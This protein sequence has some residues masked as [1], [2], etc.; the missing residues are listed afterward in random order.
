MSG[1]AE[2]PGEP[3]A[4]IT[5]SHPEASRRCLDVSVF[6]ARCCGAVLSRPAHPPHRAVPA[7]RR[8]QFTGAALGRADQAAAGIDRRGEHRRRGCVARRVCGRQGSARW[9]HGSARWHA[10]ACQRSAAE[11]KTALRS[12]QGPRSDHADRGR[13]YRLRGASFGAGEVARRIRRLCQSQSHQGLVR[14]CRD[15]VDQSPGWRVVQVDR[16]NP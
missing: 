1:R 12:E 11:S 8:I 5:P 2:H 4:H 16:G 6:I 15:R 10:P 7:R 13:P 14:T 9:L 3:H